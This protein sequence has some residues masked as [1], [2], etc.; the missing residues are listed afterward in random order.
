MSQ[1]ISEIRA[2]S[3]LIEELLEM[4]FFNQE[5]IQQLRDKGLIE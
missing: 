5:E 3:G 2:K 4:G 1:K